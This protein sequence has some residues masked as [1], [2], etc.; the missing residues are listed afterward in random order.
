[1]SRARAIAKAADRRLWLQAVVHASGRSVAV[2]AGSGLGLVLADR[3]F[4]VGLPVCAL[5]GVPLAAGAAAAGVLAARRRAKAGDAA[6]V[7]D[8]ALGLRDRVSSSIALERAAHNGEAGD[9]FLALARQDAEGAAARADVRRAIPVRFDNWWVGAPLAVG[10]L[11]AA[12]MLTPVFDVLGAGERRVERVALQEQ[13]EDAREAI[14]D[15]REQVRR[16]LAETSADAATPEQLAALDDLDRELTQGDIKP[17]DARSKAASRLTDLADSFEDRAEREDRSL[18][19]LGERFAGLDGRATDDESA[20]KPLEE[21][22][23]RNNWDAAAR[24]LDALQRE[25][26][27]DGSL[28]EAERERAARDLDSLARALENA[29]RG[30]RST[31]DDSQ[32]G[33][34][35]AQPQDEPSPQNSRAFDELR[36]RGV[37]SDRARDA[38][39]S[40]D[41]DKI[42]DALRAADMPPEQADRLAERIAQE[43]RQRE[44]QEQA[45][46][47]LRDLADAL[48]D[49]AERTRNPDAAPPPAP[50]PS[51]TPPDASRQRGARGDEQNPQER[52]APQRTPSAGDRR[53]ENRNEPSQRESEKDPGAPQRSPQQGPAQDVGTDQGD[54]NTAPGD[55]KGRRVDDAQRPDGQPQPGTQDAPGSSKDDAASPS[56]QPAPQGAQQSQRDASGAGAAQ[57]GETTR[58][59]AGGDRNARNTQQPGATD[60]AASEGD[61]SGQGQ[62]NGGMSRALDKVR[63][64]ARRRD[65]AQQSREEAERLRR[66]AQ[67]MLEDLSP[68]ERDELRRLAEQIAKERG[69]PPDDFRG[70]RTEDVDARRPT[71]TN[72]DAGRVIAEWLSE[73]RP[74]ADDAR[75]AVDTRRRLTEAAQGAQ[76]AIEEQQTPARYADLIRRYF[77]R[78]PDAVERAAP[79]G[80][81]PAAQDVAP[82][83]GAGGSGGGE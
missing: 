35:P 65:A 79:A 83:G 18:D 16:A 62:S 72:D 28:S 42:R 60:G 53:P 17:D 59:G 55:D 41:A 6:V 39:D 30:D 20:A 76:R 34:E 3:L 33:G 81:A 26:A 47:D 5:V 73:G 7:L 57:E 78:L 32:A 2:A 31:T 4:A 63:E 9:P 15:V 13:R 50:S 40:P 82:S 80:E 24:A 52:S 45:Q 43:N 8:H 75:G 10:A 66:Q 36:E 19:A 46:R 12:A 74:G 68:E 23:R 56:N 29:A 71:Q 48:D 64:L 49:A 70:A 11:V 38:A 69:A 77:Q 51:Q 14:D 67:R 61:R 37:P 21:A 25:A 58:P 54:D 22:L 1:M 27:Q 44:A